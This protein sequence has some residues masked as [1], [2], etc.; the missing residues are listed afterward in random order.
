M[1]RFIGL[2][3]PLVGMALLFCGLALQDRADRPASAKE[4]RTIERQFVAEYGPA[5]LSYLKQPLVLR[6]ALREVRPSEGW[7]LRLCFT[8]WWGLV[9]GGVALLN[10]SRP[11]SNTKGGMTCHAATSGS[12]LVSCCSS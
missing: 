6:A 8:L 9:A 3:L 4:L 2:L 11:E 10:G 12:S 1:K 5:A 7:I